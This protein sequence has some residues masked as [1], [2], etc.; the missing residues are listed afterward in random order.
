MC[1]CLSGGKGR[2][3]GKSKWGKMWTR[4]NPG[5]GH[6]GYSFYDFLKSFCRSENYC[7]CVVNASMCRPI[8]AHMHTHPHEHTHTLLSIPEGQ[9]IVFRE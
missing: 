8:N 6:K 7:V 1:V 4:M 3:E 5:K 2:G 9:A